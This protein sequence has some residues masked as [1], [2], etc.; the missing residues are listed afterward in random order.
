MIIKN[1]K[2]FCENN[3]FN[4]GDIFIKD[5]RIVGE[6]SIEKFI[7]NSVIDGS[8][9]YAIPGLTDIHFHGCVGYDFCD[10]SIEAIAAITK[11]EAENGITTICPA[12]MS[13]PEDKLKKIVECASTYNKEEGAILCGINMEG[14]YLSPKKKGAQKEEYLCKPN[15]EMVEELNKASKNLIK[16]I[17]I[18]PE[19]EGAMEF[20][21]AFQEKYVVSIAHTTADYRT[22]LKAFQR[23]AKQVTHLFNAMPPLHHR[24][25]GV[26]G[27]A[28]DTPHCMVELICDGIHIHPSVVRATIAMFGED[29]IIFISDSM[30]AAGLG[31]GIYTLGGQDVKVTEKTA[32]LVREGAIAGSVMNL[33][34]CVKTAVLKMGVPLETAVKAAAVN[35]AKAIGI[36]DLYGSISIGKIA[37]IVLVDKD[38]NVVKV[39]LKGKIIR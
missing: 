26:I 9:L 31:D 18:A 32:T 28:F 36:F 34:D 17:N 2:K 37:N 33:M 1:V 20:I 10:A 4:E 24:E 12:T 21:E 30:R 23:G 29:R 15:Y 3:R 13:L 6:D 5:D 16:I 19:M 38:L 8:G 39:I 11:Y 25:T 22:A 14:P 35:P 27:A 7:E